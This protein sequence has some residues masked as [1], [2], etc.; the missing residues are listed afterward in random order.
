MRRLCLI[1]WLRPLCASSLGFALILLDA[2]ATLNVVA[3]PS[4]GDAL[5]QSELVTSELVQ[6]VAWQPPPNLQALSRTELD[7]IFQTS[8][9]AFI[10]EA[11]GDLPEDLLRRLLALS[12]NDLEPWRTDEQPISDAAMANIEPSAD[13]LTAP[14]NPEEVTTTEVYQLS[15]TQALQLALEHNRDI[16]RQQITLERDRQNLRS[17]RADLFPSLRLRGD[18]SHRDDTTEQD[19]YVYPFT[20]GSPAQDQTRSQTRTGGYRRSTGIELRV[21]YDYALFGGTLLPRLRQS[22]LDVEQAELESEIEIRDVRR[23]VIL[24]FFTIQA[25]GARV[26]IRAQSLLRST[27]NFQDAASRLETGSGDPS[28]GISRAQVRVIQDQQSLI[29][30]TALY[31]RR[32]YEFS[33]LLELPLNVIGVPAA[34][35]QQAAAWDLDLADST[36]LAFAQRLDLD[37]LELEQD[38]LQ[39][40]LRE[41]EAEALPT[42]SLRLSGAVGTDFLSQN[43]YRILDGELASSE[44]VETETSGLDYSAG[45]FLDWSLQGGRSLAQIRRAKLSLDNNQLR[46]ADRRDAIRNQVAEA[47]FALVSNEKNLEGSQLEVEVARKALDDAQQAIQAGKISQNDLISAEEDL[48]DAQFQLLSTIIGY[49]QA[50]TRLQ[51]VTGNRPDPDLTSEQLSN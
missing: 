3:Q 42:L 26:M 16:K 27:Q 2:A 46:F 28:L 21:N 22:R 51:R 18:L 50:L 48:T 20:D 45:L 9:F 11:L 43:R 23:N 31:L 41:A 30:A 15:L 10:T 14:E 39:A 12:P 33:N 13:L 19:R 8:P 29:D 32:I 35:L 37:V 44:L 36:L 1:S 25:Q 47:Y 40:S 5:A 38:K 17:R 24:T 4:H 49:N 34:P 6:A 7:E